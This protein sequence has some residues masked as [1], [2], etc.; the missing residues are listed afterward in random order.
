MLTLGQANSSGFRPIEYGSFAL[1]NN[2]DGWCF[3]ENWPLQKGW[4]ILCRLSVPLG[5]AV[6]V[7]FVQIWKS[8]PLIN[9]HD[10]LL[11]LY[12]PLINFI[13]SVSFISKERERERER[14]G[15]WI[16]KVPLMHRLVK[17]AYLAKALLF[18]EPCNAVESPF[19][20]SLIIH[21]PLILS[22]KTI[23]ALPCACTLLPVK[24]L[25]R[26]VCMVWYHAQSDLSEWH[27]DGQDIGI[28]VHCSVGF[29][30][31][32]PKISHINWNI[33]KQQFIIVSLSRLKLIY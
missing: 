10:Q 3:K 17:E 29:L 16:Y 26:W 18:G 13:F 20:D 4:E 9:L 7:F 24:K 15:K 14:V 5:F 32:E 28:Y 8:Q 6:F 23:I 30:L 19:S 21:L 12:H 27:Q 22:S 11:G 1:A 31:S 2:L 33:A 25:P